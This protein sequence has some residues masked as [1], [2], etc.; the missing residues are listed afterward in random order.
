LQKRRNVLQHSIAAAQRSGVKQC[1]AVEGPIVGAGKSA[2]HEMQCHELPKSNTMQCSAVV[3]SFIHACVHAHSFLALP[4]K[5][6]Q[7]TMPFTAVV[8]IGVVGFVT[9]F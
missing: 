9:I 4:C 1:S 3:Q 6:F 8:L 5:C 7:L 2:W